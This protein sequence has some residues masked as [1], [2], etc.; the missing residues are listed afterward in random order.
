MIF[1]TINGELVI[2]G[3]SIDAWSE[4]FKEWA[5]TADSSLNQVKNKIDN[6]SNGNVDTF[7]YND[8]G[9]SEKEVKPLTNEN[10]DIADRLRKEQEY[11]DLLRYEPHKGKNYLDK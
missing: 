6:F 8:L 5:S 9:N 1:K 11:N 10:Y 2:A 4:K 7:S 3:K